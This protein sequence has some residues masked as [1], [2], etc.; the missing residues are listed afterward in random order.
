MKIL[1]TE[2]TVKIDTDEC[3]KEN[4]DGLCNRFTKTIYIRSVGDMLDGDATP[5]D[6]I[7]RFNQVLRHEAVHAYMYESGMEQYDDEVI[8]DWI[9]MMMPKISKSLEEKG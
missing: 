2:Y 8:V 7:N 9:A 4:A 3:K 6:R 5:D 1:G